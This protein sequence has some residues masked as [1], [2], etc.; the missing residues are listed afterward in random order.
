[1]NNERII[2]IIKNMNLLINQLRI[3]TESEGK[4][5]EVLLISIENILKHISEYFNLKINKM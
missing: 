2:I 1:M 3:E 5:F 4:K